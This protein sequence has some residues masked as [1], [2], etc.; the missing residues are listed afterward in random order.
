MKDETTD[1]HI[2]SNLHTNDGVY[3]AYIHFYQSASKKPKKPEIWCYTDKYSYSNNNQ[4]SLYINSTSDKYKLEI[5]KDG[6]RP[7]LVYSKEL[8]NG[9]WQKTP[10]DCS[11]KGCNWMLS[12]S[13]KISEQWQS[14]FYKIIVSNICKNPSSSEHFFVVTPQKDKKKDYLLVL[15]TSTWTAYNDW[16]GSNHYEGI[17][18]KYKNE[19]S[20]RLSTQRPFYKGLISL[21]NGAPRAPYKEDLKQGETAQYH[22]FN[23]AFINGYGK[24]Y[25][26]AGWAQYEKQFVIWLEKNNYTFDIITQHDLHNDKQI[27]E[28]YKCV[29][30]IGHDEYWTKEMR[31]NVDDYIED[32]GNVARFAGNFFWQTRIENN[33]KDHVCYKYLARDYDPILKNKDK[34]HLVTTS[35]DDTILNRPGSETFGLNATNGVYSRVGSSAPRSS[36]GFTIYRPDHWSLKNSDLYYGDL[37]GAKSNIAGYEVDGLPY[38]F[39]H[40]LPY[41][42]E[43]NKIPKNLEI[44][45]MS[46]TCNEEIDHGNIGFKPYLSDGD[47]RFISKILFGNDSEENRKKCRYGSGMIVNF[48]KGKGEVFHAGSCEWVA[49]LSNNDPFIDIITKNILNKYLGK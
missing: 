19:F 34:K 13:L 4:V 5:Y 43:S 33:G 44:I 24:Y 49:G 11:V 8:S 22:S 35:W 16:G 26:A 32:G 40:G 36:G 20:T 41:P 28:N 15:A 7:E 39:K 46:V 3:A 42:I 27:L 12:H 9:V 17:T 30:F 31:D 38:K 14:G 2:E 48:K 21:P 1:I 18:G 25:S 47:L 23:W 10:E 37:L 45:A 29:S 6:L